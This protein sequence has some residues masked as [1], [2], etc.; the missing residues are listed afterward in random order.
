MMK[1]ADLIILLVNLTFPIKRTY[2]NKNVYSINVRFGSTPSQPCDL[3]LATNTEW[4]IVTSTG[5][6]NDDGGCAIGVYDRDK[7]NSETESSV[8]VTAYVNVG[9]NSKVKI[10]H[11]IGWLSSDTQRCESH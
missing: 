11:T 7:S 6:A 4:T 5:C 9:Q 10:P 8:P 1:H 3:V 2:T